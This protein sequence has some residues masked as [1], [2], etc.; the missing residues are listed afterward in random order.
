[1]VQAIKPKTMKR[2]TRIALLFATLQFFLGSQYSA[3]SQGIHFSQYNNAPMLLNPANTALLPYDD[4]RAGASYRNQW[5]TVP[6]PF[7]TTSAFAD[8]GLMRFR[9]KTNWLGLGLAIFDDRVGDG[10]LALTRTE[11]FIAYHLLLNERHALSAGVSVGYAQRSVD[12]GKLY[13]DAQWDGRHFNTG[14]ASGEPNA[15]LKTNFADV[16]AGIN[17]AYIPDE[18]TYLKIGVGVAHI[19]RPSETFYTAESIMDIRPSFN[20]ELIHRSSRSIIFNPSLYYTQ[21]SGEYQLT[22]GA[23]VLFRLGVGGDEISRHQ[24]IVGAFHRWNDALIGVL[25]YQFSRVKLTT[26]YDFTLSQASALTKGSGAY[27][28][29]IIYQGLYD[30]SGHAVRMYRCPSFSNDF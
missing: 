23:Q 3:F 9:N 28:V 1:M 7:K 14:M 30:R 12:F 16:G 6:V 10:N 4:W 26:S 20:A 11:G 19:N 22:Y 15:V 27:E 13:F 17:Y 29:S 25:G 18:H 21:Q 8:F 2:T 24:L 5:S